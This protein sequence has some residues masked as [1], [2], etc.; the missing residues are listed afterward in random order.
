MREM[1]RRSK[2]RRGRRRRCYIVCDVGERRGRDWIKS[3]WRWWSR[4]GWR[5]ADVVQGPARPVTAWF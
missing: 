1:R 4:I 5:M 3:V 2:I